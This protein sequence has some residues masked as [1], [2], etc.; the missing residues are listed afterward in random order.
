MSIHSS[1]P[2]IFALL[3]LLAGC[4]SST[5]EAPASS[6]R[7]SASAT[8]ARG[9]FTVEVWADN[10][11][12]MYL[13]DTLVLEDSVP[14]TTERSFNSETFS[15]DGSYPLHLNFV[16]KDYK[17]ND[18]G[19]EYIGQ[20]KQQMGDGGFIAQVT[21]NKTG[22]VVAVTDRSWRCLVIHEAPLDKG[23]EKDPNPSETC[24]FSSSEEPQGWKSATFDT[25]EWSQAT[26][27]SKDEVRPKDGY[28]QITWDD[29]ARLIW[30]SDLETHNTLLCKVTIEAP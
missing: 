5:T 11:F 4:S 8:A 14:I 3:G 25:S 6:A 21:N 10:W 1:V 16:I 7:A 13:D 15:F 24:K 17:Q 26:E 18:T 20:P 9:E 28:D 27:Y 22:S 12:A 29:R 30:T 23:C 2:A 19:L